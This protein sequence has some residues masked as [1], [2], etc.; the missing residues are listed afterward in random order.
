M[1]P[2]PISY[3]DFGLSRTTLLPKAD[4]SGADLGAA[5][6]FHANLGLAV[7]V[8]TYLRDVGKVPRGQPCASH[9]TDRR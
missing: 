2:S 4:L 5:R 6:L 9:D 3:P 1:S 8:S 7:L